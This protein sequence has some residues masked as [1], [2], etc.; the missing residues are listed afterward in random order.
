MRVLEKKFNDPSYFS[1]GYKRTPGIAHGDAFQIQTDADVE[2][3][4]YDLIQCQPERLPLSMAQQVRRMNK[5]I[6]PLF[7]QILKQPK[8]DQK[9]DT[10]LEINA[11]VKKKTQQIDALK[12][13]GLTLKEI[14][15]EAE[16]GSAIID[17]LKD[18]DRKTKEKA[19]VQRVIDKNERKLK[20]EQDEVNGNLDM[21]YMQQKVL[22]QGTKAPVL[23]R[24]D[25]KK[26]S[27]TQKGAVSFNGMQSRR[28][29][30]KHGHHIDLIANKG[31]TRTCE[32][33]SKATKLNE[34]T[35][36]RTDTGSVR[37]ARSTGRKNNYLI[38]SNDRF[39]NIVAEN[40][41]LDYMTQNFCKSKPA[42]RKQQTSASAAR[43]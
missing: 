24:F 34:K 20:H 33:S 4:A 30:S 14:Q 8:F 36:P 7:G 17:F 25:A 37:Y 3:D 27:V 2:I 16:G 15:Q 42:N 28:Q 31:K 13:S 23:D 11:R 26:Y 19:A 10:Q 18:H 39:K 5:E 32:I 40:N 35:M 9:F 12:A 22:L 43:M 29:M 1:K 38:R 21:N 6:P 41:K